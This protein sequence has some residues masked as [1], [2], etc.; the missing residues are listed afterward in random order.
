M[1]YKSIISS[2]AALA[3]IGLLVAATPNGVITGPVVPTVNNVGPTDLFQDIVGGV[4]RA[5]NF[6]VSAAQIN[7]VQGYLNLG[8]FNT[9]T[10]TA[11]LGNSTTNVFGQ[12]AGTAASVTL[13]LPPIPGD[14]QRVCFLSTQTTTALTFAPNTGQTVTNGPT[15]GVANVSL[16]MTYVAALSTWFRSN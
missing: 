12:P 7:G 5:Q 6:Y 10:F 13:N 14:G 8:A 9:T 2:V 1:N 3:T 11:T 16:C 4:P 15:A